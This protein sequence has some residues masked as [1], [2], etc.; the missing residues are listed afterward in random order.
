[1]ERTLSEISLGPVLLGEVSVNHRRVGRPAALDRVPRYSL[2]SGKL[3]TTVALTSPFACLNSN[4][5]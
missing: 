5:F 3:A 2:G 4:W 1:V